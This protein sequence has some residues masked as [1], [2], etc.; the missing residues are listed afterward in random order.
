MGVPEVK[1]RH[2][3]CPHCSPGC[4]CIIYEDR[5]APC[6]QFNCR[7]LAD[8][9]VPDYWFPARSKIVIDIQENNGKF[10][11]CFIVDMAYPARW[12]EEPWLSDIKKWAKAGIGKW[13]CVIMAGD[14]KIPVLLASP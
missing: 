4:G 6:R 13:T 12:R 2:K 10:V 8:G 7:W 1:E 3:W 9:T 11:M 5:P 14:E